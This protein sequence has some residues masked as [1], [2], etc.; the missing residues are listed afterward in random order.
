VLPALWIPASGPVQQMRPKA[1]H[2]PA[3]FR[4]AGCLLDS[5]LKC[6]EPVKIIGIYQGLYQTRDSGQPCFCTTCGTVNPFNKSL[7]THLV[8]SNVL[9]K[10]RQDSYSANHLESRSLSESGRDNMSSSYGFS[11]TEKCNIFVDTVTRH[12]TIKDVIKSFKHKG[13]AELFDG[14][15]LLNGRI[16]MHQKS[17]LN[18]IIEVELWLNIQLTAL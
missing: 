12:D 3:E 9:G 2:E 8:N 5:P 18:N 17:I 4:T 6:L 1:F 7:F 10:W 16:V 15:V 13:L 11:R 14:V